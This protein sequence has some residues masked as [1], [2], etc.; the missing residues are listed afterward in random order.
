MKKSLIITAVL[1][2]FGTAAF[3][4]G[5]FDGPYVAL[6]VGGANKSVEIEGK[7]INHSI[8]KTKL[9]GQIS[10]GYSYAINSIFN[11]AANTFFQ[12]GGQNSVTVDGNATKM[13]NI[14]GLAVEPGAYIGDK[15]L[16]Y[17]KVGYARATL[18]RDYGSNKSNG[19]LYGV[20][21]KHLITPNVYAGLEVQQI[22]FRSETLGGVTARPAQF[23]G[24]VT[25]GY[26][27]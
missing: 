23:S 27:F 10:G 6:S 15:T 11:I 20:G 25:I 13:K 14:W 16:A 19:F 1:S 8:G 9:V 2:T 12:F 17:A 21:V 24:L 22:R 5:A 26:K 7:G 18:A 4:A 3:A